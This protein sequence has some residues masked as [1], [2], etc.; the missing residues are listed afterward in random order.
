MFDSHKHGNQAEGITSKLEE[1]NN[2][3]DY[4][5]KTHNLRSSNFTQLSYHHK[6]IVEI[7]NEIYK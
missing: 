6:M 4:L 2:V 5:G 1:L 3:F 7:T